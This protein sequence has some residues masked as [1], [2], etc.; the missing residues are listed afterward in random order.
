[1]FQGTHCFH[2]P[3]GDVEDLCGNSEGVMARRKVYKSLEWATDIAM[4]EPMRRTAQLYTL[5]PEDRDSSNL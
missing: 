4:P 3:A 5:Y 2:L 1:M